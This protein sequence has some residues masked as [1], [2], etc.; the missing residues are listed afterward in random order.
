MVLSIG[1]TLGDFDA[2]QG[3]FP[4]SIFTPNSRL[5][6][7]SGRALFFRNWKDVALYPASREEG[8]ALRQRI[9]MREI[10]AQVTVTDIRKSAT[11]RLGYEGRVTGISYYTQD[12]SLLRRVSP[13]EAAP[14]DASAEGNLDALRGKILGDAR[15][16][17]LG[18]RWELSLIHISEPTRPY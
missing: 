18:T 8:R 1:A 10:L 12:G 5:P 14:V 17:A 2:G 9:G 16:P 3:G 13:P 6:L 7:D 4:V 11:R 15:I